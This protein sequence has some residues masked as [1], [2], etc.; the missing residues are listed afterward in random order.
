MTN[1]EPEF[2][3]VEDDTYCSFCGDDTPIL[4]LRGEGNCYYCGRE[5]SFCSNCFGKMYR[6]AL[7]KAKTWHGEE[8]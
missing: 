7:E 8:Q 4:T 6:D 2:K 3:E 5:L 1:G